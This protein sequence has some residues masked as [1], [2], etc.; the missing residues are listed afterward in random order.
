MD[1]ECW[2]INYEQRSPAGHWTGCWQLWR[3]SLCEFFENSLHPY[4]K[5]YPSRIL[6]CLPISEKDYL[7]LRAKV[8]YRDDIATYAV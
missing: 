6:G 8:G 2:L 3:G 7:R 1:Q 5:E 4:M